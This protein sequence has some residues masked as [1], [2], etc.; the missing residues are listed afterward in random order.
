M[1][2]FTTKL[3]VEPLDGK[4]WRL[5]EPFYYRIGSDTSNQVIYVDAGFITDFASIPKFLWFLPYWAKYSKAAILHDWLYHAK[6]IMDEP[7][8]RKRADDIFLEAMLIEFR[9]HK[10]LGGIIAYS[11]YVAVRIFGVWR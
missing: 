11:E 4:F 9:L 2:S 5:V 6:Q 10:M 3:V 7:C 1:S 8:S